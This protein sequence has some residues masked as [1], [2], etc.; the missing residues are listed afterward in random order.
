MGSKKN[1]SQ[2]VK[3]PGTCGGR[4]RIAGRRITV[5]HIAIWHEMEG[6]SPEE[7]ASEFDLTLA[8]VHGALAYYFEHIQEIR[9][10]I[11]EDEAY[12]EEQSRRTPSLVLRQLRKRVKNGTL[13]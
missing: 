11:Q 1:D 10:R 8:Q 7:I 2:I 12:A 13:S 6:M 3:T 5:Q 4:P 9:K